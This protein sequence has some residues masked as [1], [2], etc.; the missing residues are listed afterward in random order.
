MSRGKDGTPWGKGTGKLEE[1]D[2]HPIAKEGELADGSDM[3]GDGFASRP[4]SVSRFYPSLWG[5]W[6]DAIE[7][8]GELQTD[9]SN[10][11][12]LSMTLSKE[13]SEPEFETRTV[14]RCMAI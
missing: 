1:E 14:H 12:V 11:W 3:A 2:R 8:L 10:I 6:R 9:V 13:V 4:V 7:V 5:E